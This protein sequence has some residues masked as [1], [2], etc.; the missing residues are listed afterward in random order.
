MMKG[1]RASI[2]PSPLIVVRD[3]MLPSWLSIKRQLLNLFHAEESNADMGYLQRLPQI[4]EWM[5]GSPH[6]MN[7]E[8]VE[9]VI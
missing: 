3:V 7:E 5:D 6:S 4:N 2:A 9:K 8:A 1:I